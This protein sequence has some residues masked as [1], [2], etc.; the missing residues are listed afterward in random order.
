LDVRAE[1]FYSLWGQRF[2]VFLDGQNIL[3]TKNI[4]NLSPNNWPTPP[5][6]SANDY[7][8]YYTETGRGG[9]AYVGNDVTGDGIGDWVPV[10]D[11][12]VYGDPRSIRV[13]LSYSF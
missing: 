8:I 1:K 2:Q 4:T 7:D 9:G 3:D 6:R 10:Y 12:R 13:G 5:G 11:P